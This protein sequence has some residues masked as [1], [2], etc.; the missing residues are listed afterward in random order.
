MENRTPFDAGLQSAAYPTGSERI[1]LGLGR[2]NRTFATWS[3]TMHDTISPHR[4]N[5]T[6]FALFTY[7][8]KLLLNES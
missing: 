1:K 8:S 5:T 3:Q 7:E 4:E 2:R 6:G